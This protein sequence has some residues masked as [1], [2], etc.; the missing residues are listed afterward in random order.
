MSEGFNF[1]EVDL[2]FSISAI[3]QRAGKSS[4]KGKTRKTNRQEEGMS[5]WFHA[6]ECVGV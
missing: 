4:A 2:K 5:S 6:W 3:E 1:P